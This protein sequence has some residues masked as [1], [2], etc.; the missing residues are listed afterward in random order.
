MGWF[1]G[2]P[3]LIDLLEDYANPC[4][5][6]CTGEN[7]NPCL[8]PPDL[9]VSA[10]PPQE[11]RKRLKRWQG[12]KLT[13]RRWAGATSPPFLLSSLRRQLS[14]YMETRTPWAPPAFNT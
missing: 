11:G 10:L 2:R 14:L 6:L 3:L 4:I 9:P 13:F 12:L 8:H 1:L 7:A 5:K